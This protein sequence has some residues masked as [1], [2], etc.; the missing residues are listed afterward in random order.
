M[1]NSGLGLLDAD[2]SF[3]KLFS[4]ILLRA[5]NYRGIWVAMEH[6]PRRSLTLT[7][8][9]VAFLKAEAERSGITVSDLVRRIIDTYREARER[10]SV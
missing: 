10:R 1:S 7:A 6:A 3:L 8:P 4:R 5:S 2:S 9:Q